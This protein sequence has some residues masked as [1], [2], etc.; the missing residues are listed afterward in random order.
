MGDILY[1]V[2]LLIDNDFDYYIGAW[3]N[4]LFSILIYIYVMECNKQ[5]IFPLRFGP[6]AGTFDQYFLTNFE[7]DFV[8]LFL[9]LII[10]GLYLV[11]IYPKL[12]NVT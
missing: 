11:A 7:T 8:Q 10:D 9:R 3:Q 5:V 2:S 6:Y 1:S 12:L 4:A